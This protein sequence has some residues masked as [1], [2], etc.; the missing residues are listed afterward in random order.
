MQINATN[1]TQ[2]SRALCKNG[3]CNVITAGSLRANKYIQRVAKF[4]CVQINFRGQ[5]GEFVT[6]IRAGRVGSATRES[7]KNC[8]FCV[9][10]K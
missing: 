2:A 10:L 9:V 8:P 1:E 7:V 3:E 5:T 4:Q 6:K